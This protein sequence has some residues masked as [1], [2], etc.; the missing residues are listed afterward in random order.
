MARQPGQSRSGD[1]LF[2]IVNIW[3]PA[4][5]TFFFLHSPP[6]VSAHG[7]AASI[8]PLPLGRLLPMQTFPTKLL[9]YI[10]WGREDQG[11][12]SELIL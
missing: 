2:V 9:I 10:T 4:A 5:A 3:L 1:F 11:I 8:A 12:F 7:A 6:A